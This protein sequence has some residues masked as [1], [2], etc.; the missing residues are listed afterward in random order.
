MK[1]DDNLD[2]LLQEQDKNLKKLIEQCSRRTGTL[3]VTKQTKLLL[4]AL[5]EEKK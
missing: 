4:E 1:S 3:P 2:E 5:K